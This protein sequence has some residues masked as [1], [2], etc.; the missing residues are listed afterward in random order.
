MNTQ[1]MIAVITCA[2]LFFGTAIAISWKII[3]NSKNGNGNGKEIKRLIKV[4]EDLSLLIFD[5]KNPK[6]GLIYKVEKIEEKTKDNKYEIRRTNET[7]EVYHQRID[8]HLEK[9]HGERRVDQVIKK[10]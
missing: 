6:A 3:G 5:P 2:S 1:A 4:V 10:S 8:E 9:S 7:V